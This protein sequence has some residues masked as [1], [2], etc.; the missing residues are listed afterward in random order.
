MYDVE[1]LFEKKEKNE[2]IQFFYKGFSLF[3]SLILRL[4]SSVSGIFAG[5]SRYALPCSDFRVHKIQLANIW[6]HALS[7]STIRLVVYT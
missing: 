5:I 3:A 7:T 2:L 4:F 1:A 6:P